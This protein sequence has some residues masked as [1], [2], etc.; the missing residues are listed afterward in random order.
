MGGTAAGGPI[1]TST[2]DSAMGPDLDLEDFGILGTRE[3]GEG[4]TTS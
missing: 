1:T 4:L 3:V 2:D